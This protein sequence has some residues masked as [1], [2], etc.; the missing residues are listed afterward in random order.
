MVDKVLILGGSLDQL[1]MIEL[2]Q[3][4]GFQAV[5][6]DKAAFC[7]GEG[8]ADYF[9][10]ASITDACQVEEVA[11]R[12]QVCA[13]VSMISEAGILSQWR[14]CSALDL[15]CLYSEASANA[16]LSKK[17][18]REILEQHGF[19]NIPY[20]QVKELSELS[21]FFDCHGRDIVVKQST[22]GG[23]RGLVRLCSKDKLE[24][25]WQYNQSGLELIAERFVAGREVNCV[26]T[27]TGGVIRDLLI[28]DRVVQEGA[29]G[30]VR[31]HIYPADLRKD[32]SDEIYRLCNVMNHALEIRDGVV[33]PQFMIDSITG[34]PLLIE[35]GVRI[36]GGVMDRL[37]YYIIGIDLV[38]FTLDLALGIPRDYEAY[39]V[40]ARREFGRVAFFNGPPG[41]LCKGRVSEI[42][43]GSRGRN[44]DGVLEHGLFAQGPHNPMIKEL[45][46]GGSRFYYCLTTG[47]TSSD[48]QDATKEFYAGIDFIDSDGCT[49]KQSKCLYV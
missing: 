8:C 28:S 44:I 46:D 30:V 26:Y 25:F 12:F 48:A 39:R 22:S 2:T 45:V 19:P 21:H 1:P 36:P 42:R 13:I 14:T 38:E 18:A 16:T 27:V 35:L 33:F 29:F 9:I 40:G 34:S 43:L 4:R 41:P 37:F 6:I 49:L 5:V 11:R 15:P 24:E 47:S 7:P 3:R 31:D 20:Q 17:R 32:Q 23:Q 10:N